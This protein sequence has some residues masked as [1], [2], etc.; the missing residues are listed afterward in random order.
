MGWNTYSATNTYEGETTVTPSYSISVDDC[1]HNH[2]FAKSNNGTGSVSFDLSASGYPFNL[3]VSTDGGVNWSDLG[4]VNSSSHTEELTLSEGQYEVVFRVKEEPTTITEVITTGV[5]LIFSINGHS[6]A[7]SRGNNHQTLVPSVNGVKAFMFSNAHEIKEAV[8]PL[9]SIT[10][11]VYGAANDSW[12]NIGGHW[13]ILFANKWLEDNPNT[14]IML[15][16]TARSGS[17]LEDWEPSTST[18]TLYGVMAAR[19][20]AAGGVSAFLFAISSSESV[21]GIDYDVSYARHELLFDAIKADYNVPV[22]LAS[23]Q[24]YTNR[25]D[26]I[27]VPAKQ[28][29]QDFARNRQEIVSWSSIWS[30]DLSTSDGIHVESDSQLQTYGYAAYNAVVYGDNSCLISVPS[31]TDG[32]YQL[33]LYSGSNSV[34]DEPILMRNGQAAT[35]TFPFSSG[36]L[37]GQITN[38]TDTYPL[39]GFVGGT[40]VAEIPNQPPVANAGP[41]Q[42]VAAGVLVQVSASGSNDGDGTIVGWKWRETTNS[43]I[44]L[45]STTSENISFTSPVSD[46][47]QTVT[48]EL[49]VTDDDGVDSAPVYVDFNVAAEVV[50]PTLETL[51]IEIKGSGTGSH[52]VTVFLASDIS[53]PI[54]SGLA[55]FVNDR[56]VV[57]SSDFSSGQQVVGLWLGNNYPATGCAFYG[58]VS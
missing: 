53:T 3:E 46:T 16:P 2:A 30:M 15:V 55:T 47:A 42:S 36:A 18:G 20:E 13:A 28:V 39:N 58:V 25:A 38:G 27:V 17:K 7:V 31:S 45:S 43:G 11:S 21:E 41:A 37:T 29:A 44:T 19:I 6:N 26:E 8:D 57:E 54:Y 22:Y 23:V 48:L 9:D 33:T 49:I 34:M 5:G 35:A 1:P 32:I 52:E 14:P 10:G 56:M 40:L 50:A 12:S 51:S 24:N 4:N